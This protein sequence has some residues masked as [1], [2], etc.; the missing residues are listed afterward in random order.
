MQEVAFRTVRV[1]MYE[2]KYHMLIYW[3]HA[4]SLNVL[5]RLR[6]SMTMMRRNVSAA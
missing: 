2:K 1:Y 4:E 5:D 3:K 6:T